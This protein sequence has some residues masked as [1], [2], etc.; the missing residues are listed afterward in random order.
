[1]RNRTPGMIAVGLDYLPSVSS[2][3]VIFIYLLVRLVF[4]KLKALAINK[5][6]HQLDKSDIRYKLFSLFQILDYTTQFFHAFNSALFLVTGKFPTLL[7][8]LFKL[9]LHLFNNNTDVRTNKFSKHLYD[10]SSIVV[11][12]VEINI[13]SRD[14]LWNELT[15]LLISFGKFIMN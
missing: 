11:K 8:R 4:I 15:L 3:Y 14:L 10:Y 5:L 2:N 6:W 12:P 9:S 1:M 7:H 13:Q